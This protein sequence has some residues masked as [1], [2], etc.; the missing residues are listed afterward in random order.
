MPIQ[1]P[2]RGGGIHGKGVS[3]RCGQGGRRGRLAAAG[4]AGG[5]LDRWPSFQT[6]QFAG[7]FIVSGITKD[8]AG[9]P[10]P[11]VTVDLY[12]ESRVWLDRTVSDGSGAYI[13]RLVGVGSVF[14]VA[15]L[16]G[17]PE[18]AG[19]TIHNVQPVPA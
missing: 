19:T 15:Y 4:A 13:F 11:G 5:G 12:S 9:A 3:A 14:I 18:V 16:E 10:L 7:S 17:A 1:Q 6:K 8:A 2:G